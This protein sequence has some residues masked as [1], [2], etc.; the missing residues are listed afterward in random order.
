MTPLLA[1][2]AWE[3]LDVNPGNSLLK[4]NSFY[5]RQQVLL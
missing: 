5:A 3:L 4:I 2:L 1:V